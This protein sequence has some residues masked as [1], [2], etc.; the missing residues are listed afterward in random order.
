MKNNSIKKEPHSKWNDDLIFYHLRRTVFYKESRNLLVNYGDEL[1]TL[2]DNLKSDNKCVDCIVGSN[3]LYAEGDS[4]DSRNF[5]VRRP[6]DIFLAKAKYYDK[7][8]NGYSNEDKFKIIFNNLCLNRVIE[9]YTR[10]I[11]LTPCTSFLLPNNPASPYYFRTDAVS[12]KY[13]FWYK[14][15]IPPMAVKIT[16][17]SIAKERKSFCPDISLEK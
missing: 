15:G 16:L 11:A 3:V 14:Y 2:I 5:I 10:I 17:K 7:T 8:G 1:S 9:C 13:G 12:T 6:Y 4:G